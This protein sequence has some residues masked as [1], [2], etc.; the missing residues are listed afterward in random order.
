MG[1]SGG[2]HECRVTT[3]AEVGEPSAGWG[4]GVSEA[5]RPLRRRDCEIGEIPHGRDL[6][7]IAILAGMGAGEFCSGG[8]WW[9]TMSGVV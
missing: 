3:C 6:G 9:K 5:V 4:L 1:W 8:D 7:P 2:Q